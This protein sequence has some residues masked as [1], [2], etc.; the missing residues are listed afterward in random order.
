MN[1]TKI[2]QYLYKKRI[3]HGY[4]LARLA[5]EFTKRKEFL[6]VNSIKNWEKG[7]AI[8][9]LEKLEA[10]SDIYGV[11][12]DEILE[13]EKIKS[14]FEDKYFIHLDISNWKI[15]E[16]D[17]QK[18]IWDIKVDQ[19]LLIRKNFKKLVYKFFEGDISLSQIN[20]LNFLAENYYVCNVD[21]FSD[22]IND[23]K[24]DDT[25]KN[26]EEKWWALH[27]YVFP[28]NSISL[29]LNALADENFEEKHIERLFAGLEDWE[30]DQ[31]LSYIQI[32]KVV[33]YKP[34]FN[35]KMLLD[36]ET[37]H[38]KE[39]DE[40]QI[41]KDTIKFL[42]K[43]GACINDLYLGY[44]KKV[45]Y[46]QNVIERYF[47]IYN[48]IVAPIIIQTT[49]AGER[50]VYNVK[51]TARN[52]L[53]TK[54]KYGIFNFLEGFGY[55]K[56]DIFDLVL[57]NENVPKDVILNIAIS[58]G[59]DIN[60]DFRFIEADLNFEIFS[61]KTEWDEFKKEESEISNMTKELSLVEGW[62][63]K[64]VT[65]IGRTYDKYVGGT[66]K[67]EREQHILSTDKKI[68]YAEF[69]K[70]RNVNLSEELVN[71]IDQLS[72]EVIMSKYLN[73]GSN[74]ERNK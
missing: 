22:V 11:S 3:E 59:V 33:F 21:S 43:N 2:G 10:L 46:T 26:N 30:K 42:I 6:S 44:F 72:L 55:T 68:T 38:G 1:K 19:A 5:E 53:V 23:I 47:D 31:L 32:G 50:K 18:P 29:E 40:T 36:Y 74:N 51:N 70:H 7:L 63:E 20:E 35:S 60:R 62:L 15:N 14:N 28:T 37:K 56:D 54:H 17:N 64:G 71:K 34:T 27:C 65:K 39:F 52:R 58:K 13:G 73:G 24:N 41:T 16:N 4:T 61:L 45:A 69:K 25:Y 9:E 66:N 57:K 8:P 48:Q 67:E 12:I 49:I